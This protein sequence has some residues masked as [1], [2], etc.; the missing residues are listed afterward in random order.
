MLTKYVFK[1]LP[2]TLKKSGN[3]GLIW[4]GKIEVSIAS[5]GQ[6]YEKIVEFKLPFLVV[7][8]TPLAAASLPV[9]TSGL[10]IGIAILIKQNNCFYLLPTL[11]LLYKRL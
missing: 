3:C 8:G 6:S 4:F 11:I 9:C 10:T 7:G 1:T 5:T 2:N